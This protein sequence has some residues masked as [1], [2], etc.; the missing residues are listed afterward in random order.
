M[1][2]F[3]IL[4]T[5]FNEILYKKNLKDNPESHQNKNENQAYSITKQNKIKR[6]NIFIHG[7][8]SAAEGYTRPSGPKP[9]FTGL[10]R[11]IKEQF[12]TETKVK[13]LYEEK[14]KFAENKNRKYL[15]EKI[16]SH[17]SQD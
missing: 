2:I 11:N 5:A 13:N 12:N 10:C 16:D 4:S 14:N 7:S 1:I 6:I 3:G 15:F 8:C 9:S 17:L